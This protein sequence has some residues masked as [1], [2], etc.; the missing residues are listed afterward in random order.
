MGKNSKV[1]TYQIKFVLGDLK[2]IDILDLMI[3]DEPN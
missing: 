3:Q 2:S 1:I